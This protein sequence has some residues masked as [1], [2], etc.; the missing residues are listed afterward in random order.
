[1]CSRDLAICLCLCWCIH[2]CYSWF[3]H[4]ISYYDS[5]RFKFKLNSMLIQLEQVVDWVMHGATESSSPVQPHLPGWRGPNSVYCHASRRCLQLGK[6]MW[7]L[8]TGP[9]GSHNLVC[10]ELYG[11][12]VPVWDVYFS[13]GHDGGRP[14]RCRMSRG[15]IGATQDL[16]QRGVCQSGRE[17]VM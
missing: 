11:T 13:F 2:S 5:N 8:C 9:L 16:A 14:R 1:M 12:I 3:V 4:F 7:P 17:S 6:A 15:D 10:P